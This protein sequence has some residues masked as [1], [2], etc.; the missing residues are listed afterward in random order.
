MRLPADST[1]AAA[2]INQLAARQADDTL[3]YYIAINASDT[4]LQTIVNDSGGAS[5]MMMM[6]G[7]LNGAK[8]SKTL[9]GYGDVIER[10]VRFSSPE[11]RRLKEE[12]WSVDPAIQAASK[13]AGVTPQSISA[14]GGTV[15]YDYYRIVVQSMPP[16]LTPE[17]YLSEMADDL[18][19]AVN[20]A[21]FD[22]INKFQ[23][24]VTS[25]PPA[26][27]DVV[28][29]DILGPDNGSV[30]LVERTPSHFIFQT[31]MTSQKNTGSHPEYG[32]REF[33]FERTQPLT[34]YTKG[35][36]RP[37]SWITGAVGAGIQNNGWTSMMEGIR[38]ELTRRGGRCSNNIY[39]WTTA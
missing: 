7:K 1:L 28:D 22:T 20:N 13:S 17:D 23:R 29:I 38:D 34:F 21:L 3:S 16:N 36:S 9:T 12:P 26:V 35:A 15:V 31:V 18:N 19:K 14:G 2:V 39:S 32:S 27:G 33:G 30:M 10:L 25:R 24:A 6:V 11:H 5:L 8:G 4:Q 37:G